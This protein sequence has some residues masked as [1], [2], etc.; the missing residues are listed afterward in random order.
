MR[1]QGLRALLAIVE[2]GSFS[3]AALE[4]GM[5][6]SSVSYAIAELEQE[7]GVRLLDRGRFGAVATPVGERIAVHARSVE[8]SLAA[9]GQ[10]ATLDRGE[11]RGEVRVSTFRSL[12]AH[13][14]APAMSELAL[15]HPG[16]RVEFTEVSSR[17][18]D[19]L[20]GLHSGRFDVA[21]TMSA[22]AD[23]A[24]FWRLFLDP[25]VAVVAEGGPFPE[26]SASLADLVAHP[27]LLSNGPCSW[28]LREALL[29]LD[30]AFRPAVEVAEDSTM[31][32]LAA[33][34]LGVAL[35]PRLTVDSLPAGARLLRLEEPLER[36]LGVA[37]LPGA[38]KV[39][40]VRVFLSALRAMFPDSEVPEL[41]AGAAR[42]AAPASEERDPVL[43]PAG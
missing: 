26:G 36:S 21:L 34:G 41:D 30:P 22:L 17:A 35:M 20:S 5:S 25:Y 24:V 7:L 43:G 11:L 28:P 2:H 6:Q 9:I 38:L 37:L 40:A 13:V 10:E 3:E 19:P 1:L 42:S 33:R 4:L 32:A 18:L 15:T 16:L 39:P 31:L 8:R 23:S 14:L 12:A 27:V 29:R